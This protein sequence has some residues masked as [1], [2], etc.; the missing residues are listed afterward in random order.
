MRIPE[1][2]PDEG[3]DVLLADARHVGRQVVVGE[4][5]RQLLHRAG[6]GQL[7]VGRKV[8]GAQVAPEGG[9]VGAEVAGWG[10]MRVRCAS[11]H[12]S[13]RG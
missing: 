1:E 4:V 3:F 7:G 9:E 8:L 10:R 6:V 2:V 13:R 5:G 11:I 12:G